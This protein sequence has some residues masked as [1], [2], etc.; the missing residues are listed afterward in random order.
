M[1]KTLLV[2]T[3][4]AAYTIYKQLISIGHDVWVIGANDNEPLA[5]ISKNFVRQDYS[6]V[7]KLNKLI[8][9]E[10]YDFVIPGCTDVSYRACA[11]VS[12]GRFMGIDSI[13]STRAINDKSEFRRVAAKLGIPV[14]KVLDFDEALHCD[15]VIVKPV[16][17]FS[18]QGISIVKKPTSDSLQ[19]AYSSGCKVSKTRTAIIEEFVSGQLYS[20][21]AFLQAGKVVADLV[22][23]EDC[24]T[25]LFTVDTSKVVYDFPENLRGLLREDAI[26]LFNGLGLV[27]GLIHSQFILSGDCYWIIEVTR[28]C[29]GDLY[30]VL[31]EMST[32]YPYAASYVAPFLGANPFPQSVETLRRRIIRHTATSKEGESLWGFTF[33]MPVDLKFFVPLASAGDF[34]KPNAQ[35]RAG[36]F[37]IETESDNEQ[38]EIYNRLLDGTLYRLNYN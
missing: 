11:E 14:P 4:R 7:S 1:N 19:A 26:K 31:I 10:K 28:R 33:N 9:K 32:G 6:D 30:A 16:D 34:I 5:K 20:H 8:E 24:T 2:D 18:G 21:S 25:N 23:R 37:F 12:N 15:V 36:L 29:P 3:N 13:E 38:N 17:S 22:V 27:D 35:G